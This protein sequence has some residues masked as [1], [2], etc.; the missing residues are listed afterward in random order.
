MDLKTNI[1]VRSK[2]SHVSNEFAEKEELIYDLDGLDQ[3]KSG[4]EILLEQTKSDALSKKDYDTT[5]I[6]KKI[7]Q[8]V[9]QGMAEN[10]VFSDQG[11]QAIEVSDSDK[12]IGQVI[13]ADPVI[14]SVQPDPEVSP[15]D[16]MFPV[17]NF[18]TRLKE[19][20]KK[21]NHTVTSKQI[22][23][24]VLGNNAHSHGASPHVQSQPNVH[25][26]P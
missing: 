4:Q 2:T 7:S 17:H 3:L 26:S 18:D 23:F 11:V 9:S 19:K 1:R 16:Y 13:M 24:D 5:I 22:L 15:S 12:D 8:T 21:L 10:I 25:Q 20:P 14:I 6:S